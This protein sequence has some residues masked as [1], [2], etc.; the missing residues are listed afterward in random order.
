MESALIIDA[1]YRVN[2]TFRRFPNRM[3]L[4]YEIK[5]LRYL[6]IKKARESVPVT[7]PTLQGSR[8]APS[9]E[10]ATQKPTPICITT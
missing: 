7:R 5:N 10:R 2:L 8:I 1:A 6:Y 3:V 4:M 9:S